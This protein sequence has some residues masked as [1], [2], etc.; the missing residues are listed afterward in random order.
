MAGKDALIKSQTGSGKTLAY[1]LPIVQR[2][3]EMEPKVGRNDGVLALVIVPTRELAMQVIWALLCLIIMF[4]EKIDCH[5]LLFLFRVTS[6]LSA[7]A[8][9]LLESC[10]AFWWGARSENPKRLG[11]GKDSIS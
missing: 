4:E 9:R 3:Q 7:C 6:G 10:L 5:A 11:L 1:A 2:M 8:T